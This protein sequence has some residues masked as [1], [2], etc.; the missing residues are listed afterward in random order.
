MTAQDLIRQIQEDASEW[1]EMC[2][3]PAALVAGILA[4]KVIKLQSH[5]EYLEKRLE[6]VN[7]SAN[8]IRIYSRNS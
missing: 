8:A 4:Q 7:S 1:I 2:E 5:I 6:H 3:D